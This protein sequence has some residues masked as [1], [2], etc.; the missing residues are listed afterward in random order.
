MAEPWISVALNG[1]GVV[2]LAP[3]D[4]AR[5]AGLDWNDSWTVLGLSWTLVVARSPVESVAVSW[6]SRYDRYSWSGAANDPLATPANVWIRWVWQL[7][8]QWWMI[9]VQLRPEAGIAI[10]LPSVACPLNAIVSPT[11]Q[12][13]EPSGESMTGDGG[14]EPGASLVV[15]AP[16]SP[17]TESVTF[18]PTVTGP[19]TVY[20]YDG[21]GDAESPKMPSPLRSHA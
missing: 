15:V 5:P 10:P 18:S 3:T 21:V 4:R 7:D 14:I 17:V 20:V 13:N 2:G 16:T 9:S 6:S 1:V 12:V 19:A 11:A 8:G